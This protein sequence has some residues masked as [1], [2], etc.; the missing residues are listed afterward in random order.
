MPRMLFIN[1][2]VT[3]VAK[4]TDFYRSIGAEKNEAFSNEDSSSLAL[5]DNLFVMVHS[6]A[7]F[8][9]FTPKAIADARTSTEMLLCLSSESRQCVDLLVEAAGSAGGRIDPCPRQEH[10]MMYGRSFEDLDGHIW[11]VVWMDPAMADAPPETPTA[12]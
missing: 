10:D 1:L 4:A 6:H 3:D 9:D 12:A 7:R 8:R 2:P 11:E 5:S